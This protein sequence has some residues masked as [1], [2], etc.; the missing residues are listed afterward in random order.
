MNWI[1]LQV[2]VKNTAESTVVQQILFKGGC[3]WYT[4][5]TEIRYTGSHSI[6]HTETNRIGHHP[7]PSDVMEDVPMFSYTQFIAISHSKKLGRLL[8]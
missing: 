2:R 6:F 8:T 7:G 5:G 3:T 4:G 1:K